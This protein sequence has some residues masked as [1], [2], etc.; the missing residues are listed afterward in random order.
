MAKQDA[1]HDE[2]SHQ[3]N[4][5]E[6]VLSS[7]PN[8]LIVLQQ[9]FARPVT[10]ADDETFLL[11][12]LSHPEDGRAGLGFVNASSDTLRVTVPLRRA[13]GHPEVAV[14]CIDEEVHMHMMSAKHKSRSRS[15]GEASSARSRKART[16]SKDQTPSLA[17]VDQ[18]VVTIRQNTTSLRS[19]VGDTGSVVWRSS[20]A[21]AALMLRQLSPSSETSASAPPLLQPQ[22]FQIA[23][24]L[25]LGA[26]TGV[27]PLLLL[28]HPNIAAPNA[29]TTWIATDQAA[30]MPLLRRNLDAHH[31]A[32]SKEP[33]ASTSFN[34]SA[35][36]RLGSAELDWLEA[37]Q[38]WESGVESRRQR[39]R[40]AVL[41][42][43]VGRS[44]CHVDK[45]AQGVED[46][47][48]PDLILA[49]DCI[50]NPSLF[51]ALLATIDLF[52]APNRTL[53]LIVCELRSAETV[54][55]WLSNWLARGSSG[56]RAPNTN[57]KWCICSLE[58]EML[59]HML[60]K[61][62]AAWVAWRTR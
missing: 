8:D 62:N 47:A 27:L 40:S 50:Y 60:G 45:E 28:A 26:G 42:D 48:W 18:V 36:V 39:F 61:G 12:S 55:L 24:I 57:G 14:E 5:A 4:A 23:R 7:P 54:Q 9:G 17:E 6:P 33:K 11:Y 19:T 20:L 22:S 58:K 25:E 29:G 49:S 16:S 43:F 41:S 53:A 56:G 10:N 15:K 1:S 35:G 30:M 52:C 2:A 34:K 37:Q 13:D 38:A 44:T 46:D 51:A 31:L 32:Q 3:A 21:L 59:G